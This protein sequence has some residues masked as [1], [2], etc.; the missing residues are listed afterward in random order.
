MAKNK[1]EAAIEQLNFQAQ[2]LRDVVTECDNAIA[3]KKLFIRAEQEDGEDV[4]YF[5]P[6]EYI[7]AALHSWRETT[8]LRLLA[9]NQKLEGLA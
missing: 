2:E 9:V 8:C 6:Q 1:N 3:E 4:E 7:L 5:V